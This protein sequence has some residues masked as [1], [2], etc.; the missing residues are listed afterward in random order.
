MYHFIVNPDAG[1]RK[2]VKALEVVT[3]VFKE[4]GEAYVIHKA[5][6]MGGARR[7]AAALTGKRSDAKLDEKENSVSRSGKRLDEEEVKIVVFGGDGTLHEVLNGIVDPARCMIGLIPSG[8]GNDFAA[9]AGIPEDPEAA[10]KV[11]LVDS[12]KKTDY[13]N[14]GGVRCMNVGGLGIDVDVLVRYEKAKKKGKLKY[15]LCLIQSL[16]V[17]KGTN[18][19]VES[20]GVVTTHKALIAAACN[21]KKIGGGIKICPIAEIDDGKIDVN[22]V[23]KMG[24]FKIIGAFSRLMK[25]TI[26]K[27]KHAHYARVDRIRVTSDKPFPVQLDGE[28]YENVAFDVIVETD[29]KMYRP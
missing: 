8:T 5:E 12:A 24:F 3:R 10:A 19:T 4:Y 27:D 22:V 6:K 2:T 20:D 28:I 14:V 17:Y 29:L 16:F 25:G 1:N 7:A 15:L 13:L 18:I 26:L 23:D 21:G 11:I 9:S